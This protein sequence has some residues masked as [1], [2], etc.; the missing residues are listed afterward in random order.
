MDLNAL[1]TLTDAQRIQAR[2]QAHRNLMTSIYEPRL[3][4]FERQH[5]NRYGRSVRWFVMAAT[6]IVM[7]AAFAI[8]AIHVYTVGRDA[9]LDG[10]GGAITAAIVGGS[11]VLIAEISVIILSMAPVVWDTTRRDTGLMAVGVLAA[12]MVAIIGNVTATIPFDR[13]P[14]DWIGAWISAVA[15]DPALFSIATFPPLLTVLVGTALKS[16]VLAGSRDRHE[17]QAA[18]SAALDSY[19]RTVTK[20]EQHEN[21]RVTWGAA[22]WDV[23]RHEWREYLAAVDDDLK[24]Q[25]ILRE[26]GAEDRLRAALNS[27]SY[28][29][30]SPA[31]SGLN[32]AQGKSKKQIVLDHLAENPDAVQEDQSALAA[33]LTQV[34]GMQISQSTV[35]RAVQSFSSNGHE[36]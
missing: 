1:P 4:D 7:V 21:W 12:A 36:R 18:Y 33:Y 26:M 3:E 30:N 8:S 23:W 16:A 24:L 2:Q 31:F 5:V 10:G 32:A 34:S 35:S 15:S 14:F 17:A 13:G 29:M 11:F 22:L 28:A 27:G 9:Y 25:I 20:L 6:L 19:R